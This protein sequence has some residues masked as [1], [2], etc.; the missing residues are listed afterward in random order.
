MNLI[1]VLL[2]E[3]DPNWLKIF[4]ILVGK[5]TQ[6]I[7][8]YTHVVDLAFALTAI[9]DNQFN[10]IMLDLMLPDSQAL[11]TIKVMTAQANVPIVIITTLD[12]E[13]LMQDAFMLGVEDYLIKD[14]Y[15]IGI[16]LHVSHQAIK[17]FLA[18]NL[19]AFNVSIKSLLD[20]L[21]SLDV[22]LAQWQQKQSSHT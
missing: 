14:K 22:T 16:F 2:V 3:D 18:K 8:E 20:N 4:Q 19:H 5:E 13:K 12:D 7:F 1:K 6:E 11:N 17:R 9:K 15:D 10:L 21:Q